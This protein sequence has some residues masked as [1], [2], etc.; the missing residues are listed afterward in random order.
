[1]DNPNDLRRENDIP[2]CEYCGF[3]LTQENVDNNDEV[4]DHCHEQRI[5]ELVREADM[6]IL[7]EMGVIYGV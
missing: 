6:G 7:E 5:D 4:C 3:E 2:V 1:M